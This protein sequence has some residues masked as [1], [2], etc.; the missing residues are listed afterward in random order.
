MYSRL[1]YNIYMFFK[2]KNNH[3]PSFNTAGIIFIAQVLHFFVVLMLISKI[4]NFEIP[5]FSKDNSVNKL[6]F[7]PIATIWLILVHKFYEKKIELLMLKFKNKKR[8]NVYLIL[9]FFI[10][11]PLLLVIK[12]SGGVLWRF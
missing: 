2:D 11:I 6:A 7:F 9:L 5:T 1:Y 10:L 3:D 12:L 8:Y 4:L